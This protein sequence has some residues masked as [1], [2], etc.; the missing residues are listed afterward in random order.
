MAD[1]VELSLLLDPTPISAASIRE[2]AEAR[3]TRE[4]AEMAMNVMERRQRVLGPAYPFEVSP[5]GI[6]ARTADSPYAALL[7]LSSGAASTTRSMLSRTSRT[8]LSRR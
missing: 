7:V 1:G 5:V 2:G 6:K 4:L 3:G 8:C